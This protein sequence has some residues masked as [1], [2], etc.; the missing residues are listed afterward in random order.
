[1]VPALPRLSCV[2]GTGVAGVDFTDLPEVV[3]LFRN[4][5]G[6][7]G[8]NSTKDGAFGT[9]AVGGRSE[10]ELAA[11][12]LCK[13]VSAHAVGGGLCE[14]GELSVDFKDDGARELCGVR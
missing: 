11:P 4:K 3:E 12:S 5:D 8:G 9:L 10:E 6:F 1:M 7:G 13:L 2:N 14:I